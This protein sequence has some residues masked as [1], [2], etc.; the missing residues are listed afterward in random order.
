MQTSYDVI[1]IGAGP[2][3]GQ[4]ARELA[5]AGKKVLLV[6]K[7][8]N[9]AINN[10]SSGG[11]PSELL[12]DYS[13]PKSIVGSFW[14]K[15]ALHSS[16]KLYEWADTTYEGVVLDFMK[17]RSFLADQ[18][19]A[20]GSHV[21]LNHAYHHR[22]EKKGKTFVY[23]KNMQNSEIKQFNTKVLVD[24]TGAERKVLQQNAFDK[25]KSVAIT[26]IEYLIQ[27]D[28]H[29]YNLYADT[30]SFFLGL[31]WMPQGYSWIFPME[32]D[33]LKVGVVRYF[34]HDQIVPHESSYR[35]YLDQMLQQCLG[36][37]EAV[38][39]DTHGKTI[40]YSTGQKDKVFAGNVLA[41]G[42]SIS[43]LNP[44]ASEGIRHAM[45]SGRSSAHSILSFLEG[46]PNSFSDYVREM[47]Q[48]FGFRWKT[49]EF[50][51]HR[52]YREKNDKTLEKYAA[53][54]KALSFDEMLDFTF[55]YKFKTVFKF[56]WKY[57]TLR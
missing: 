19:Q 42:D 21:L 14:H 5:M 7:A 38:V 52:M 9:F 24:A 35:A 20:H 39:L 26:G 18:V 13:L 43:T 23:L 17:L 54:F 15:I 41:I 11:A 31:K 6:E 8:K 49:S 46:N 10:Y 28:S 32:E 40:F 45:Y 1:V 34:A 27:V 44:M 53:A 56:F 57:L 22:E 29:Q 51:M 55:K 37:K 48:Y 47:H 2:A 30:L 16:T 36:T 50:V 12:R 3:G 25:K 33:H 4:C